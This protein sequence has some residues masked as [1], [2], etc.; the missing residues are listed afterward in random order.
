MMMFS[1]MDRPLMRLLVVFGFK[2]R[3]EKYVE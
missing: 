1:L 3:P 2:E